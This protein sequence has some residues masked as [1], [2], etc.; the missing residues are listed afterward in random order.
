[1]FGFFGVYTEAMTF[2]LVQLKLDL[3]TSLTPQGRKRF[4]YTALG[5]KA[6]ANKSSR[7]GKAEK[8]Y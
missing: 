3:S 8:T 1:M 6:F 7:K 5:M 4:Y 2:Y